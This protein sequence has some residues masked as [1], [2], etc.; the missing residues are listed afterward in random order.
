MHIL[1][2][3]SCMIFHLSFSHYSLPFR[4]TDVYWL[5]KNIQNM[6]SQAKFHAKSNGV[7][8]KIQKID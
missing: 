3:H 7:V 5:E 2:N 8:R 1:R 6:I 4:H